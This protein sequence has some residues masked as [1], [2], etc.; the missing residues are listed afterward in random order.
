MI[1][2]SVS[3]NIAVYQSSLRQIVRAT[4]II[5]AG[6]LIVAGPW[7]G[8]LSYTYG[9]PVFSTSGPINHAIVGPPHMAR[10]HP[11]V[12]SF[13]KPGTGRV[14]AWEDPT[15]L[16][17]NYWSPFE[18]VAY[19]VH[20]GKIIHRNA[21]T[22]VQHLKAFDWLGLGLISALFGYL[23]GHPWRKSLRE[24]PWR[25]SFIPIASLV[26]IYLPVCG[27]RGGLGAGIIG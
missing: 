20:Q 10:E 13:H 16:P 4:T 19:A 25:L 2:G 24:E 1:I 23:L 9:H 11:L 15:S 5:V 22:I 26:A 7:I 6:F 3:T 18:N 8:I 21:H 27:M 17:Y 12:R 14:T